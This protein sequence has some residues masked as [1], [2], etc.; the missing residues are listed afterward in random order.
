MNLYWHRRLREA[1]IAL[2]V[3]MLLLT[4][5]ALMYW[6]VP[7]EVMPYIFIGTVATGAL[8]LIIAEWLEPRTDER[9]GRK[10]GTEQ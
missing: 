5:G 8:M 1:L 10:G 7:I 6:F 3:V 4:T 9:N 2:G